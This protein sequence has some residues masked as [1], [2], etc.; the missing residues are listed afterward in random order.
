M[1]LFSETE[2][3]RDCIWEGPVTQEW[4]SKSIQYEKMW[5]STPGLGPCFSDGKMGHLG[6]ILHLGWQEKQ[7]RR[8]PE[9]DMVVL[10]ERDLGWD[11]GLCSLS[12]HCIKWISRPALFPGWAFFTL[13]NH[14]QWCYFTTRASICKLLHV[15]FAP[16]TETVIGPATYW[17]VEVDL[18]L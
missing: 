17:E 4:N 6:V 5:F 15:T 18:F 12:R 16:I 14:L 13:T 9:S 3:S 7:F 8:K 10:I 11:E 1:I 2:F